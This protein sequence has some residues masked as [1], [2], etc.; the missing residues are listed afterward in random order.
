MAVLES[1]E[2]PGEWATM[3]ANHPLPPESVFLS[4]LGKVTRM[5]MSCGWVPIS[6]PSP[7]GSGSE[8]KEKT[9]QLPRGFRLSG[10]RIILLAETLAPLWGGAPCP[11]WVHRHSWVA[12]L[13]NLL[14]SSLLSSPFLPHLLNR[15]PF[16]FLAL[17]S[18]LFPG[19]EQCSSMAFFWVFSSLFK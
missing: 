3:P 5:F 18:L 1:Q 7:H 16:I 15:T 19:D 12:S 13:R 8:Q 6:A 17:C 9:R 11:L 14:A 2:S 10:P 4:L